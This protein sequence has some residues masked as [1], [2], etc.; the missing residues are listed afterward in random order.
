MGTTDRDQ[1]LVE[2]RLTYD[3]ALDT[4]GM[5]NALVSGEQRRWIESD[6]RRQF[7][8]RG[9]EL[10]LGS[11][12]R[13]GY[14]DGQFYKQL[15]EL[16]ALAMSANVHAMITQLAP[17][18]CPI[19]CQLKKERKLSSEGFQLAVSVADALVAARMQIPVPVAQI[20]VYVV[21]NHV[22]DHCCS[23]EGGATT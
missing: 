9:I 2:L 6:L 18:V 11:E 15:A 10:Y 19:Y 5:S 23:C 17:V 4:R 21:K 8:E 1:L 13:H 7:E 16:L 12:G 22:L 14:Q 3:G 20:A